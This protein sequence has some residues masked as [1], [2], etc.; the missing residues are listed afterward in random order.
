VSQR[1]FEPWKAD[2]RKAKT[3]YFLALAIASGGAWLFVIQNQTQIASGMLIF[4]MVFLVLGA[5]L[6]K[7]AK[8]REY[9]KRLEEKFTPMAV[10]TLRKAGYN[11]QTNVMARGIGD[12]DI[13]V[14]TE[15]GRAPIEIKSFV[16]W[17]QLNIPLLPSTLWAG[18]RERKAMRQAEAQRNHLQSQYAIIWLPNG[19]QTWLQSLFSTGNGRV[20]VVFGHASKLL[21]N[22]GRPHALKNSAVTTVVAGK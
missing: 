5:R 12:I 14:Q 6:A 9:G 17:K 8:S 1:I 19:R 7:R 10:A 22:I 18:D 11:V 3:A 16:Y 20:K 15:Q 21:E 2:Q 4:A 13:V